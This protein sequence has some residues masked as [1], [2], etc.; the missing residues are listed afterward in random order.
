MPA[1]YEGQC[2]LVGNILPMAL[3]HEFKSH[4][5]IWPKTKC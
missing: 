4:I 2:G 3:G 1:S 5:R